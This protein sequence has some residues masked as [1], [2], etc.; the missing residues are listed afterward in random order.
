MALQK[1]LNIALHAGDD[2]AHFL[3]SFQILLLAYNIVHLY[4]DKI[5]QCWEDNALEFV[6]QVK[7][8]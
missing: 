2:F 8:S 6:V 4:S 1:L 3:I 5:I 7:K